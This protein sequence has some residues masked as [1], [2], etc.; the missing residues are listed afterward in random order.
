MLECLGYFPVYSGNYNIITHG[1]KQ[2]QAQ[3]YKIIIINPVIILTLSIVLPPVLVN[4]R[5]FEMS[6]FLA[7]TGRIR[8]REVTDIFPIY[9]RMFKN[10][11][12]IMTKYVRIAYIQHIS[13]I[14]V[15]YCQTTFTPAHTNI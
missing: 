9:L 2:P 15:F 6:E 3:I 11:E 10:S 14:I 8:P 1:G 5:E 13:N 7:S 12:D 4:L